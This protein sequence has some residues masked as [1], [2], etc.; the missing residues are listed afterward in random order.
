MKIIKDVEQGT[1]EWFALRLASIGGSSVGGITAGGGK[2]RKKKLYEFAG[3]LITGV[4]AENFKFQ[5]ADRGHEHEDAARGLYAL[6]KDVEVEQV[7]LVIHDDKHKHYSPDGL[8]PGRLQEIKVR[9]PSVWIGYFD[10]ATPPISDRKQIQWGLH[11]C[12]L[13]WCDY[14][15]YC[16]EMAMAGKYPLIIDSVHRDEKLIKE[17]DVSV[18]SFIEEMIALVDKIKGR[19]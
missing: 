8:T 7:A 9:I 3:E 5:H 15:Q 12:E 19:L 6:E 17:L 4:K 13:D 14:I 11:I 10:G 2:T 16:P 18:D 1:D